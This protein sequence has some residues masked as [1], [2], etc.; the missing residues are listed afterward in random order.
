MTPEQDAILRD[1]Q[2]KLDGYGYRIERIDE[3]QHGGKPDPWGYGTRIEQTQADVAA[4]KAALAQLVQQSPVS[5]LTEDMLEKALRDVLGS[6]DN[7]S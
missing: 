6:L 1:V 7:K 3:G 2:A 4:I 5:G